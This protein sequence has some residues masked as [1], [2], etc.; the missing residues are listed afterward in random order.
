M[1]WSSCWQIPLRK[2]CERYLAKAAL[3]VHKEPVAVVG[4]EAAE[5]P[6]N[7]INESN[8]GGRWKKGRQVN[9]SFR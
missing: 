2:I 6:E 3:L 8:T 9:R 5:W 4:G 1:E 7:K